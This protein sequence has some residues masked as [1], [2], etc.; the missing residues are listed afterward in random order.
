MDKP[1][2]QLLYK[3]WRCTGLNKLVIGMGDTPMQAYLLWKKK[4]E[5][6]NRG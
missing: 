6:I 5:S 4:M 1:R 3:F 2:L